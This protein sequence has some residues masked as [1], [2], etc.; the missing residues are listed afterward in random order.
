L[1][2]DSL[3]AEPQGKFSNVLSIISL[4]RLHWH[5]NFN[6]CQFVL[7][8]LLFLQ[9]NEVTVHLEELAVVG[10]SQ[11]I[12]NLA[13]L[14]DVEINCFS[15]SHSCK[16][17]DTASYLQSQLSLHIVDT[18]LQPHARYHAG[19][20]ELKRQGLPV[21]NISMKYNSAIKR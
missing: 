7:F 13:L 17:F 16:A 14:N 18:E 1:Q 8:D 4:G 3:P 21:H 5:A 11:K 10:L 12:R 2:A 9:S 15:F 6:L 19:N 20:T